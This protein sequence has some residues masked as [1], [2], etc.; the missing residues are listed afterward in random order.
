MS[1]TSYDAWALRRIMTGVTAEVDM[2]AMTATWR[3][4]ADRLMGYAAAERVPFLDG[5]LLARPDGKAVLHALASADPTGAGAVVRGGDRPAMGDAGGHAPGIVDASW[6][7]RG[8]VAGGALT[9]L[10]AD[11]GIGKTLLAMSLARASGRPTP[12]RTAS[13]RRSHRGRRPSGCPATSI[14][15]SSSNWPRTMGCPTTRSC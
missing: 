15:P 8:W 14:S 11:P 13:R 10:A 5:H 2:E 1:L 9:S 3:P 6:P 12:G 4:V 7:W